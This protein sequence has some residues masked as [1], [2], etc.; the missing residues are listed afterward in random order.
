MRFE[1]RQEYWKLA[2]RKSQG[3]NLYLAAEEI[4]RVKAA[5]REG[6]S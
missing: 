3:N 6:A 5:K 1:D 4:R 2:P